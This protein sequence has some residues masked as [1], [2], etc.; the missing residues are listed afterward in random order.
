MILSSC[1]VKDAKVIRKSLQKKNNIHTRKKSY[2]TSLDPKLRCTIFLKTLK[3]LRVI[4][5]QI[6]LVFNI[7]KSLIWIWLSYNFL[8]SIT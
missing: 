2:Q 5:V 7:F 6:Y 3:E 8:T 4:Y 1:Y